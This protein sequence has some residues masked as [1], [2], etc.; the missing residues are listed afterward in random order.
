LSDNNLWG[1]M[2]DVLKDISTYLAKS[3]SEQKTASLQKPPKTGEDQEA[4]KGGP[5]PSAGP[6][7][8]ALVKNF[9]PSESQPNASEGIDSDEGTE[10][11]KEEEYEE[12][13][14]NGESD[15]DDDYDDDDDDDEDSDEE[16][17]V[18][19]KEMGDDVA[20]LKSLLKDIKNALSK[21]TDSK[22]MARLVSESVKKEL[23]TATSKMLRKMGFTP[24]RPDVVR[25]GLDEV[26]SEIRKS[27]DTVNDGEKLQKALDNLSKKSWQELGALREKSGLFKSFN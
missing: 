3:D 7:K 10:L 13:G 4:I 21:S 22:Q 14:R 6:G 5:A 9:V 26:N 1:E 17:G 8:G 12:G 23:P 20:E 2:L 18:E 15:D 24:S 11:K 19:K 25:L 27:E 16:E